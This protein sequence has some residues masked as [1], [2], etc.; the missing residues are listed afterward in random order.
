MVM[1]LPSLADQKADLRKR[2]YERRIAVDGEE[3]EAA[4]KAVAKRVASAISIADGTIVSAYWP[5]PGE[6]DPRPTLEAL[7]KQGAAGA[8]PRTVGD[9]EPLV[10]HSWTVGDPL[11]EGQFKVME[12][13]IGVPIV[14]PSVLLIPLLAFD[15]GCR[16]L[17]HGKGYYDRSLQ[18]LK[19]GDPNLRAIG[20]AYALQEVEQVPTDVYDQTLDLVITEKGVFEPT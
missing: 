6:L 5:L 7:V 4:A 8:L 3:A 16:R 20:V 13:E 12:P 1:N 18:Q 15:C 10:F 9:G 17:G 11:V 14:T 19:A 2:C